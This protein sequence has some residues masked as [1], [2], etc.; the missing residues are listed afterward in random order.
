MKTSPK[1]VLYLTC[2]FLGKMVQMHQFI[3]SHQDSGFISADVG[4]NLTLQCFYER[5]EKKCIGTNKHQD[6]NLELS[7]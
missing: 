6:R 3:L 1:F 7:Q 2:F 4:D 5:D